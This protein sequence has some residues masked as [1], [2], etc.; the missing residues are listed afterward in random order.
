VGRADEVQNCQE[1]IIMEDYLTMWSI[2]L[3]VA[4]TTLAVAAFIFS[5]VSY[6]NAT[7]L[8]IKAQEILSQISQK[9][10]VVVERT[11]HQMD[12]AWDYFTALPYISIPRS[13][14]DIFKKEEE[15]KKQIIEEARK[16]T[17]ELM[18][19]TGLQNKTLIELVEKVEALVGK[20]SDRTIKLLGRERIL[21]SLYKIE[22]ELKALAKEH[23]VVF[24]KGFDLRAIVNNLRNSE[25]FKFISHEALDNIEKLIDF[26]DMGIESYSDEQFNAIMSIPVEFL[27]RYLNSLR[28]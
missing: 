26:V 6:R 12:K 17:T 24:S 16:E 2:F 7:K 10:E 3:A 19:D 5:W 23:K 25:Q 15:L 13:G 8:Q 22:E 1:V 9:V 14:E 27:I 28:K 11:T 21:T 18:K 20:S 4:S